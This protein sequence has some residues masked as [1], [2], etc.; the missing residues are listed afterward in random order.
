MNVEDEV[1]STTTAQTT[2]AGLFVYISRNGRRIRLGV[3]QQ[4]EVG[5]HESSAAYH[6]AQNEDQRTMM[7]VMYHF[8]HQTCCTML[9]ID[10]L[11]VSS[12]IQIERVSV[13]HANFLS[14]DTNYKS[15]VAA[16]FR[17]VNALR[18]GHW[19]FETGC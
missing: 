11:I 18:S 5:A 9:P 19:V 8:T 4:N 12:V 1:G 13:H 10:R 15:P 3:S 6:L 7:L 14:H 17:T 16:R 2:T